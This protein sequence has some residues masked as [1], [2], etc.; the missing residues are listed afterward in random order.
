MLTFVFLKLAEEGEFL[1]DELEQL[2]VF[3]L[4]PLLAVLPQHCH[5]GL[6]HAQQHFDVAV[7]LTGRIGETGRTVLTAI[8][9]RV[10]ALLG[11]GL[12]AVVVGGAA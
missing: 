12:E 9:L 5:H 4:E 10:A 1:D 11:L 7:C 8:L 2:L 3:G 6:R